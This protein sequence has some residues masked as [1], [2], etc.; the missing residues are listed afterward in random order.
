[1]GKWPRC[2]KQGRY[3]NDY[4]RWSHLGHC[5]TEIYAISE[6]SDS[7]AI[8]N[9]SYCFVFSQDMKPSVFK[10][11]QS[12]LKSFSLRVKREQS[13]C[14]GGL[15]LRTKKMCSLVTVLSGSETI[16]STC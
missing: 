16:T 15:E 11:A 12:S 4:A 3:V 14:R 8:I 5:T 2:L 6:N 7:A 1:M 9:L 13:S 10:R